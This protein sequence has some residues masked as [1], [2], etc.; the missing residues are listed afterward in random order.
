MCMPIAPSPT[1]PTRMI[2]VSTFD[3]PG[4]PQRDYSEAWAGRKEFVIA[5]GPREAGCRTPA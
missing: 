4:R 1:K 3:R 5:V 2:R